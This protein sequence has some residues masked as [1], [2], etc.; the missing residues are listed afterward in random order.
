LL[1]N[2]RTDIIPRWL[3]FRLST[4]SNLLQGSLST[5]LCHACVCC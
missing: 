5:H 1:P 2:T 4:P 3:G